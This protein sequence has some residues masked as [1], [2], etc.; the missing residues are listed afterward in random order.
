MSFRDLYHQQYRRLTYIPTFHC[1]GHCV[2]IESVGRSKKSIARRSGSR[3]TRSDAVRR[4][5]VR[6]HASRPA[7]VYGRHFILILASWSDEALARHAHNVSRRNHFDRV[8]RRW[9]PGIYGFF[10][11][12]ATNVTG[13]C[14][15]ICPEK[16]AYV[17]QDA[18]PEEALNILSILKL[19]PRKREDCVWIKGAPGS[20][21]FVFERRPPELQIRTEYLPRSYLPPP[22]SAPLI[23]SADR[24]FTE[25]FPEIP[26]RVGRHP[27]VR[28]FFAYS[29]LILLWD[30]HYPVE[31]T[32]AANSWICW[33]SRNSASAADRDENASSFPHGCKNY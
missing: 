21:R 24:M 12:T 16:R 20:F 5:R 27:P 31:L 7:S 6:I 26:E 28:P 19:Q 30:I 11:L 3:V 2:G 32:R 22:L 33:L 4:K 13:A 1:V 29:L 23:K 14:E 15:W 25:G 17:E 8:V 18:L 9:A 10:N